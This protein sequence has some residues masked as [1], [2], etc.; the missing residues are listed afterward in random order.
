MAEK[1]K[2]EVSLWKFKQA[3]GERTFAYVDYIFLQP[4]DR[5]RRSSFT[6]L[7]VIRA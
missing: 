6:Q 3:E 2:K 1:L 4:D 7:H 5:F